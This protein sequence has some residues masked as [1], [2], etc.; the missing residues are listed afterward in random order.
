MHDLVQAVHLTK[1][2]RHS[3]LIAEADRP[4]IPFTCVLEF[5]IDPSLHVCDAV[6]ILTHT[7]LFHPMYYATTFPLTVLCIIA[8]LS[9][10]FLCITNFNDYVTTVDARP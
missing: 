1:R 7:C 5:V 2:A 3:C 6:L 4:I 8:L 9:S 10:V